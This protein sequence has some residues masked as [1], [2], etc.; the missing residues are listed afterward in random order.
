MKQLYRLAKLAQQIFFA[1]RKYTFSVP[2]EAKDIKERI[3]HLYPS[4]APKKHTFH[5]FPEQLG[6]SQEDREAALSWLAHTEALFV[7]YEVML[8]ALEGK[9]TK[10]NASSHRET[11]VSCYKANGAPTGLCDELYWV[12]L[13]RPN[14]CAQQRIVCHGIP[15]PFIT[16]HLEVCL[17]SLKTGGCYYIDL[18]GAQ[19]G[20]YEPV[21]K[22][23]TSGPPG[24]YGDALKMSLIPLEDLKQRYE[25]EIYHPDGDNL[26]AVDHRSQLLIAEEIS[27]AIARVE[28]RNAAGLNIAKS[29]TKD[30]ATFKA[31]SDVLLDAIDTAMQRHC[32]VSDWDRQEIVDTLAQRALA[33]GYVETTWY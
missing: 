20:R 3:I 1:V 28:S 30:E 33:L 15:M 26:K 22:T 17:V 18:C 21:Y 32:A 13:C 14:I 7:I 8:K 19:F 29:L 27:K 23:E 6:W 12:E 5:E 4:P 25:S 9:S 2:L 31:F 24:V 16:D 10:F 11:S